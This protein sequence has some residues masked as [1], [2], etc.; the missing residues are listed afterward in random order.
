MQIAKH[1]FERKFYTLLLLAK[2]AETKYSSSELPFTSTVLSIHNKYMY[3]TLVQVAVQY[4]T[5]RL[6]YNTVP[7]YRHSTVPYTYRLEVV[8]YCTVP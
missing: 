2:S 1:I 5:Q 6:R 8:Q 7:P 3:R 4:G